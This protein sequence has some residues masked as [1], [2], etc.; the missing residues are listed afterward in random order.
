MKSSRTLE[1][2]ASLFWV[3]VDKT[4][5]C[6]LWLASKNKSGYGNFRSNTFFKGEILAHRVS[7]RL[8]YGR[9]PIGNVLHHCDTPACV[10]PAHLE[11]VTP[12]QNVARSRATVLNGELV[13]AIIA[14]SGS[15]RTIAM[16]LGVSQSTVGRVLNG[17]RVGRP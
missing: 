2:A 12:G 7:F 6:W 8:A 5:S 16:R 11:P 17:Y 4:E 10:N 14:S 1:E 15:Q 9:V 13:A 3:K